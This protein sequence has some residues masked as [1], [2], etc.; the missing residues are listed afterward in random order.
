V[1]AGLDTKLTYYKLCY[2]LLHL[3]QGKDKCLFIASN[4][5]STFPTAN[6]LLLPGTFPFSNCGIVLSKPKNK[7]LVN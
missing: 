1:I 3:Q 4:M 2:A 5:D 6:N 7:V